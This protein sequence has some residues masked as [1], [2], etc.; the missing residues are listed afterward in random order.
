MKL[1][2]VNEFA[3][4]DYNGTTGKTDA[5]ESVYL[6]CKNHQFLRWSSKNPHQ[7]SM[8]YLGPKEYLDFVEGKT[9]HFEIADECRQFLT[10]E[11]ECSF[12]EL[13]VIEE[14]E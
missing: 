13:M 9:E 5:P 14:E 8:H 11:C 4:R 12:S 7:R 1:T 10:R 6:T 3:F 2:P